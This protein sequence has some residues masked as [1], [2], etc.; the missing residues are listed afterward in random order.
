[1]LVRLR[2]SAGHTLHGRQSGETGTIVKLSLI[3]AAGTGRYDQYD[4]L[5]LRGEV[6]VK[7]VLAIGLA[8]AQ[9]LSWGTP[10]IHLCVCSNGTVCVDS[11]P[12][13]CRCSSANLHDQDDCCCGLESCVGA[14]PDARASHVFASIVGFDHCDCTHIQLSWSQP[15]S[16]S[17]TVN[18]VDSGR[19]LPHDVLSSHNNSNGSMSAGFMSENLASRRSSP[20]SW[21]L[22]ERS[23]VN[24]RC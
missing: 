13:N 5:G 21:L 24:L 14:E 10:A 8:V 16:L 17:A 23:T 6:R 18:I 9:F 2:E 7:S 20:V 12:E 22:V 11:G 3:D 15:P 19:P 4:M 1:V